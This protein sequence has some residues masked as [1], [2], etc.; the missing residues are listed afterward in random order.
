M[1]RAGIDPAIVHAWL[2]TGLLVSE[3]NR[4]LL[5]EEDLAE[6]QAAIE[7][8]DVLTFR[9]LIREVGL[10]ADDALGHANFGGDI[11]DR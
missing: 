3:E 11:G 7:L 5:S 4:R 2:R 10:R 6:W 8:D 9:V 1:A